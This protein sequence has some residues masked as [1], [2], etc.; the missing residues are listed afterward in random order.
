M[1]TAS[2]VNCLGA[3][4]RELARHPGETVSIDEL[5]DH[6]WVGVVVTP[7]SVYQAVATLRHVLGDDPKQPRYIAT[8]PRLGYRLIAPVVETVEE[9]QQSPLAPDLGEPDWIRTTSAHLRS[10]RSCPSR[11]AL[12][13][14]P[15]GS[16]S[17]RKG[18]PP[19]IDFIEE[20]LLP[21]VLCLIR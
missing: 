3:V 8:V 21:T 19:S 6:V 20:R 18:F 9:V 17:E 4:L 12:A 2:N 1:S 16:S 11:T 13:S 5:L 10:T 14:P 15:R 7:D